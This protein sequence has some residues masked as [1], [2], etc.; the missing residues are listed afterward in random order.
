[1]PTCKIVQ[2]IDGNAHF[3][4]LLVVIEIEGDRVVGRLK[5][6]SISKAL[7]SVCA[8]DWRARLV[9]A[10]LRLTGGLVDAGSESL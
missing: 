8:L 3:D 2:A 9:L 7:D 6:S 1:M 5:C 10:F 4:G